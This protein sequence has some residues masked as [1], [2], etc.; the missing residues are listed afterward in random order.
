MKYRYQAYDRTGKE[1]VGTVEADDVDIAQESLRKKGLYVSSISDVTEAGRAGGVRRAG[2]F[3]ATRR[4]RNL[5]IFSRQL[6]VLTSSGTTLVDG[7]SALERQT[8]DQKWRQVLRELRME[9][10]QGTTLNE[11]M[12]GHPEYFDATLRSM[13]A[14]GESG[15]NLTPMLERMS[16]LV[17][18]RLRV[19]KAVTGAMVYPALLT[20]LAL[21]VMIV[22]LTFVVPRF[23][24][25]FDMLGVPLP[26]TTEVLITVSGLLQSYWWLATGLTVAA[27]VGLRTAAGTRGGK[28]AIDKAVLHIPKFGGITRNFATARIVR[29]LGVLLESRVPLLEALQL[30]REGMSNS[31]YAEL[32]A[33]A[34]EAVTRGEPVSSVFTDPRLIP[35]SVHEA[36]RSG[37]SSGQVAPL[38]LT[39][40]DFLDEENEVVLRSLTSIIEPV[41]LVGLGLLV[42]VVAMSMFTPLFDLTA[43]TGAGGG[44]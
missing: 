24:D 16:S 18:S 17:E 33:R 31:Y 8:P 35:T 32:M 20:V 6:Y 10:E 4:L 36:L 39:V 7:L 34:E 37:E 15:G 25:L 12:A 2:L 38:L 23:A 42:G 22:L 3:G 44:G 26:G 41:I 14:A 5:T 11:A 40:A 28:R 30:T 21:G 43:M 1:T 13:V 29:L 27:V 19:R 9:V